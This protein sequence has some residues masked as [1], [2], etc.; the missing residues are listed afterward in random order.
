MDKGSGP[1]A[2]V[3]SRLGL[4]R[5]DS[6]AVRK[7]PWRS[8][9]FAKSM[10]DQVHMI[11][12]GF[13]AFDVSCELR[14]CVPAHSSSLDQDSSLTYNTVL[15]GYLPVPANLVNFISA[16]RSSCFVFNRCTC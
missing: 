13:G 4:R 16:A 12:R 3:A 14:L 5:L 11:S 9:D 1:T 8:I 2:P 15:L 7:E 10:I 6:G